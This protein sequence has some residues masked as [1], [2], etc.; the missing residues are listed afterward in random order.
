MRATLPSG[1]YGDVIED[2]MNFTVREGMIGGTIS[3]ALK[4]HES[5]TMTLDV[6]EGY[7]AGRYASW[8]S[9]WVETALVIVFSVL[10]LL[11]WALTLRSRPL[12]VSSRTA[13][14]DAAA[15]SDLPYL[16]A[17]GAPDFNMLICHW[18]ALGYLTIEMDEKGHVLLHRQVIMGNERK[19]NTRFSRRCFPG[20]KFATARA[21]LIKRQPNRPCAPSSGT[22]TSGSI[23]ARAATRAS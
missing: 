8:S 23:R 17:G 3:T 11:Y 12:R 2:Y 21:F 4:D 5:L 13:P 10:A 20:A 14:P 1:Y 16:L 15:P 9:G 7:F 6:G 22:G 18:A 19:R